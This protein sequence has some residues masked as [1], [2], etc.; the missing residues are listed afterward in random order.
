MGGTCSRCSLRNHTTSSRSANI[1]S[2]S[3]FSSS[4]SLLDWR[5]RGAV[6]VVVGGGGAVREGLD[7]RS[8]TGLFL[9]LAAMG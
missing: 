2:A 4:P 3:T 5:K 6:V 9:G 1:S 8:L 7:F